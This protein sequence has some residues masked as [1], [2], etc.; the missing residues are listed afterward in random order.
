[1]DPFRLNLKINKLAI[2]VTAKDNSISYGSAAVANSD[3]YTIT[4]GVLAAVDPQIMLL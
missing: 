1:M 3:L 4:S 2:S